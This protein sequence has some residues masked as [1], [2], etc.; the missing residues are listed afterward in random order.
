MSV[1]INKVEKA[2]TTLDLKLMLLSAEVKAEHARVRTLHNLPEGSE[3][4][5]LNVSFSV[6]DGTA[7]DAAKELIEE[8]QPLA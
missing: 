1:N 2:G 6:R 4:A 8:V 5:L 7:A 3:S